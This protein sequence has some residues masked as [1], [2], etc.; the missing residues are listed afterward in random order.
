[1]DLRKIKA[2]SGSE[3]LLFLFFLLVSCC[4]WLML[5]LN[6]HYETD[7]SFPVHVKNVPEDAGFSYFEDNTIDV[8]V[9]DRGATLMNYSFEPFLPII[10][11]YS[12]LHNKKGRLTISVSSLKKR[13]E[14]QLLSSTGMIA[15]HPDTL[16][17][18]TRESAQNYPV[19]TDITVKAARQYAVGE[20]KTIPDSVL[21]FAPLSVT[22]TLRYISTQ[23]IEQEE[24]R[25]TLTID[26]KLIYA[27]NVEC[28]PQHVKVVV[29]IT[30][31]TEKTFEIP[32]QGVNFP[33]EYTLKTFPSRA[34]I[35]T[36]VNMSQLG[37]IT[38]DDFEV[39]VDY[40][41]AISGTSD[42]LKLRLLKSP[43][44]VND[45]RIVPAEVEYLIEQL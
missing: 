30:P 28:H 35:V 5:T 33:A 16:T 3:L 39:G 32:I 45:I 14:G 15:M 36:N 42:R 26:A 19:K 34:K 29:P 13:I 9:R 43:S 17:Y 1:M 6:Q 37:K 12:E 7:I 23:H 25:D 21:V 20:I 10:I 27:D 41:D 40:N 11:D 2:P 4:L 24:L 8:R 44:T 38:A 31:Y 18:Y 22:D